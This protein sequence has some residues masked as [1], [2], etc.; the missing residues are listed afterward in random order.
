MEEGTDK[1]TQT[2]GPGNQH[3]NGRNKGQR[4]CKGK[5]L[6][7]NITKLLELK[8]V[9]LQIEKAPLSEQR[10]ERKSTQT[11]AY[12]QEMLKHQD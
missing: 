11:N 4:K 8:N 6:Q 5:N 12:H 2:S 7:E 1:K 10:S 3:L 9:G